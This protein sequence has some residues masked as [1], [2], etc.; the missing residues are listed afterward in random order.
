MLAGMLPLSIHKIINQN[1]Q[2]L[3]ETI[4]MNVFCIETYTCN[5]PFEDYIDVAV[6][7][8]DDLSVTV[9][10]SERNRIKTLKS[11]ITWNMNIILSNTNDNDIT[12]QYRRYSTVF[13]FRRRGEGGGTG[14][15]FQLL[16][17]LQSNIT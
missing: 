4:Q 5:E 2:F 17:F 12:D 10:C 13:N 3:E 15:I 6:G 1:M 7:T 11:C 14:V 16:R 8:N 9:K